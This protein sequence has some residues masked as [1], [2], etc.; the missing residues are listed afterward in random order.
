M[1]QR[2]LNP[3]LVINSPLKPVKFHTEDIFRFNEKTPIGKMIKF[4]TEVSDE[5]GHWVN[6]EVAGVVEEK[7]PF[8][9]KLDDGRYY[10][11][12]DYMIGYIY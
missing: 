8:I 7:Y 6:K 2:A 9:F 12:I 3:F 10:K 4:R 11:W 5:L 1:S